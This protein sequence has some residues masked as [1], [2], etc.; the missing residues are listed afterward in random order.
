MLLVYQCFKG[1]LITCSHLIFKPF[2]VLS[3]KRKVSLDVCTVALFF[4]KLL[5]M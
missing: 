2:S 3:L 5:F 4:S 1:S